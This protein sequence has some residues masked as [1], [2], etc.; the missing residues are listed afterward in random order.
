[1]TPSFSFPEEFRPWKV[2]ITYPKQPHYTAWI[3][4]RGCQDSMKAVALL[5]R[6]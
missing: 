5:V 4:I 3:A 2:A 1:M 6:V